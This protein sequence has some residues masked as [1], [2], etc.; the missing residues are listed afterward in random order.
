[1]L[2]IALAGGLAASPA[3]ADYRAGREAYDAKDFDAARTEWTEA[4]VSGDAQAQFELGKMLANGVGVHKDLVAAYAWLVIADHGGIKDARGFH[5]KLAQGALPRHCHYEAMRLVRD[6]QVGD[7]E[8]LAAGGLNNS[9]CWK[10]DAPN[11]E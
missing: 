3:A 10:F 4:A 8:R 6:F 2:A 7:T 5:K 11:R 1:L 9:R